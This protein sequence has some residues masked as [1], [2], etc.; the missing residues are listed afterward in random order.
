MKRYIFKLVC[1]SNGIEII[2]QHLHSSIYDN[3]RQEILD[4]LEDSLFPNESFRNLFDDLTCDG[5]FYHVGKI[6]R[7]SEDEYNIMCKY[8]IEGF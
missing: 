3:P 5:M 2:E 1:C 8:V 4:L 7:I 6:E